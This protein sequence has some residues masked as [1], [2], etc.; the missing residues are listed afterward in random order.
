[1]NRKEKRGIVRALVAARREVNRSD[2]PLA[3]CTAIT[4]AAMRGKTDSVDASMATSYIGDILLPGHA[5]V[6]TWLRDCHPQFY[7]ELTAKR[8]LRCAWREYRLAWIDHMLKELRHGGT[9][10]AIPDDELLTDK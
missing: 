8:N 10:E 7:Q 5:F 4:R 6:T 2:E 3:V 9:P 1:M